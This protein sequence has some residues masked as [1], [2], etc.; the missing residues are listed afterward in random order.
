MSESK[1]IIIPKIKLNLERKEW[2]KIQKQKIEDAQGCLI[3]LISSSEFVKF[4]KNSSIANNNAVKIGEKTLEIDKEALLKKLDNDEISLS[5]LN[6]LKKVFYS[7]EDQDT[8]D[9]L[10]AAKFG[11]KKRNN[12]IV[13]KH[14]KI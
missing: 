2:S 3:N 1:E 7:I 8:E 9:Q 5:E 14:K 10:Y 12:N 4:T 6:K 13:N 11:S